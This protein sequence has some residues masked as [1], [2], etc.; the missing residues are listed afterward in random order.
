[1][2]GTVPLDAVG[3]GVRIS[4]Q[5]SRGGTLICRATAPQERRLHHGIR[6]RVFVEE[7][8]VFAASDLDSYDARD[9]VIHAIAIY[10]G[11]AAGTVRLFPID[12][13]TGL[14]QGDRLAVLPQFR[15]HGLGGPLVRFAVAVAAAAGGRQMLAHVQLANVRFF[16]RLGWRRSAAVETYVGRPHQPM[17]I[18]LPPASGDDVVRLEPSPHTRT[19]AIGSPASYVSR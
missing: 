18:A 13:D 3:S 4:L 1:M 9:D 17:T 6:R 7:Q 19:G 5:D 16:E 11:I 2:T 15:V 8:G 14:W 12:R 10:N